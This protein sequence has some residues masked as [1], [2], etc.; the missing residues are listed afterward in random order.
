M[1]QPDAVELGVIAAYQD[2]LS[3]QGVARVTGV[4]SS[5]VQLIMRKFSPGSIRPRGQRFN[6]RPADQVLTLASLGLHRVGPCED[7][8]VE[9][10]SPTRDKGQACGLCQYFITKAREVVVT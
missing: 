7:C 6:P 9:M 1:N 10:V 5:R 8:G 4:G 3:Y 2:G